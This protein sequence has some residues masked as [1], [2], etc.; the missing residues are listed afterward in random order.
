MKLKK[1]FDDIDVEKATASEE[2]DTEAIKKIIQ[3][4]VGFQ[5]V[6]DKVSRGGCIRS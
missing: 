3:G 4:S 6:N 5:E 1:H 2:A